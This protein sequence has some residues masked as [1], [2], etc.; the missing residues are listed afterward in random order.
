MADAFNSEQLAALSTVAHLIDL[1]NEVAI[2]GV[3]IRSLSQQCPLAVQT[4]AGGRR[5]RGSLASILHAYSKLGKAAL[6][7]S[8]H[9][10][11][12]RAVD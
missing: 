9:V 6:E 3:T 2:D 7:L 5:S 4:L 8:T 12:S 10:S 1:I 11:E